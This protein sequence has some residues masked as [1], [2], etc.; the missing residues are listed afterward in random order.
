MRT[1]LPPPEEEEQP[2]AVR[3]EAARVQPRDR[4]HGLRACREDGRADRRGAQP[5]A[6]AEDV[7]LR[8]Q[9]PVTFVTL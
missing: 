5:V 7:R 9:D 1:H 2:D 3:G 8:N 6:E 4:R